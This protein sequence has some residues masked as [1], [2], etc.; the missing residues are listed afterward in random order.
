MPL[1]P[2]VL[3]VVDGVIYVH[4][5]LRPL[6][7]RTWHRRMCGALP[8]ADTAPRRRPHPARRGL[9]VRRL[10]LSVTSRLADHVLAT[11]ARG[12]RTPSRQASHGRWGP[13]ATV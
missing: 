4:G 3:P 13:T 5:S 11:E 6:S 12:T 2:A 10:G 8:Q 1:P 7:A 9:T